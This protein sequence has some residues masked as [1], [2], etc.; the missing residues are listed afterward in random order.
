MG[1]D[2]SNNNGSEATNANNL[3]TSKRSGQGELKLSQMNLQEFNHTVN[4]GD[5]HRAQTKHTHKRMMS[6]TGSTISSKIV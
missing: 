6:E 1:M 5:T 4:K 2:P 3:S